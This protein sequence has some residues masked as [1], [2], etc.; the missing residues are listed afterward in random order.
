MI[1]NIS[2]YHVYVVLIHLQ[3]Q[4]NKK[5][6]ECQK[7]SEAKSLVFSD[8][9]M[10]YRLFK[11]MHKNYLDEICTTCAMYFYLVVDS[12]IFVDLNRKIGYK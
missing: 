6:I 11:K 2:L 1:I 8:K 12:H 9:N 10:M 7:I 3:F 5:A 4:D